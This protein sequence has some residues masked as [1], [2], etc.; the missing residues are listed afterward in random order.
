MLTAHTLC[1]KNKKYT[2]KKKEKARTANIWRMENP[3]TGEKPV[4]DNQ[5][6]ELVLF[7]ALP[8]VVTLI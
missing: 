5:S 2:G 4:F 3:A 1:N 6:V 7:Q 8:G